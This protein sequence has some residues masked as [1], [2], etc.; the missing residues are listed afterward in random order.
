[1]LQPQ[2]LVDQGTP[3]TSVTLESLPSLCVL[4]LPAE[5]KALTGTLYDPRTRSVD[6]AVH[7]IDRREALATV[8][9]PLVF[10]GSRLPGRRGA[11]CQIQVRLRA[12]VHVGIDQ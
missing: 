1:M 12:Q 7:V 2:S 3:T 10:H 6:C 8:V 9:S 5:F 4:H 11:A